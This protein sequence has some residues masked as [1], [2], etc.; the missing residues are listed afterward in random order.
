M[1][2]TARKQVSPNPTAPLRSPSLYLSRN[3]G[4]SSRSL[5]LAARTTRVNVTSNATGN[6]DR[7]TSSQEQFS[8]TGPLPNGADESNGSDL[9]EKKAKFTGQH[10]IRRSSAD[11]LNAEDKQGLAKGAKQTASAWMGWFA[12]PADRQ[13]QTPSTR[14]QN[15]STTEVQTSKND[16]LFGSNHN[17][18][19]SQNESRER[20]SSIPTPVVITAGRDQAPRSWLA[21]WGTAAH[22]PGIQSEVGANGATG[23]QDLNP[24]QDQIDMEGEFDSAAMALKIPD[25]LT[26]DQLVDAGK[27]SGWAFWSRNHSAQNATGGSLRLTKAAGAGT[28]DQNKSTHTVINET[29][30]TSS[31]SNGSGFHPTES[32]RSTNVLSVDESA[33][34]IKVIDS[35]SSSATLVNATKAKK[36]KQEAI[37]LLLPSFENTYRPVPKP[38]MLQQVIPP[39]AIISCLRVPFHFC[40]AGQNLC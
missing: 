11:I 35:D 39:K 7:N 14:Q 26:S 4:S 23:I 40:N 15:L 30:E 27:S 29:K 19:P 21:L 32:A 34:N 38:G 13:S 10:S 16:K 17:G 8:G 6:S 25:S 33:G 37:N 12:R 24:A 28:P 5:P 18:S 1:A 3:V 31:H 2:E 20:R 36:P 9:D 22:V